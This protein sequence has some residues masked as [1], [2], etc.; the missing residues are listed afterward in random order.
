MVVPCLLSNRS[1]SQ[2]TG[3]IGIEGH[4]ELGERA[5]HDA[6]QDA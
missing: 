6:L 5:I 1:S 4:A 2:G 3:G